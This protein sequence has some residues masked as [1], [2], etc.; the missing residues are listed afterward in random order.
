MGTITPRKRKDGSM[1]YKAQIR[2]RI[3]G[4][5]AYSETQTFDRK[6]AAAARRIANRAKRTRSM[7]K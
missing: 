2:I 1:A 6:Q 5:V 3:Q 4:T 7:A